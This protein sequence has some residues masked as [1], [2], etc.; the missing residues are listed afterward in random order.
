MEYLVKGTTILTGKIDV[1]GT[2]TDYGVDYTYAECTK[3]VCTN[4]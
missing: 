4:F 3:R 2:C 1:I